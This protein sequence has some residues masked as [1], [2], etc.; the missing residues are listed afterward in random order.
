MRHK[1][2]HSVNIKLSSSHLA[3]LSD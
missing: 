1:S 2:E 3:S